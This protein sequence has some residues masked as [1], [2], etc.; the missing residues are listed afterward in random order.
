MR[1]FLL[2]PLFLF[3]SCQPKIDIQKENYIFNNNLQSYNESRDKLEEYYYRLKEYSEDK[4]SGLDFTTKISHLFLH[5]D[6]MRNDL[7][8]VVQE[9]EAL[10]MTILKQSGNVLTFP[11]LEFRDSLALHAYDFTN[12]RNKFSSGF[13]SFNKSNQFQKIKG[14]VFNFRKNLVQHAV[15]SSSTAEKKYSF[16]DPNLVDFKDIKAVAEML[17]KRLQT[18]APDDIEAV[19]QV[20][21]SISKENPFL[22]KAYEGFLEH[23]SVAE[24]INILTNIQNQIMRSSVDI[25]RLISSRFGG[26]EYRFNKIFSLVQGP[27]IVQKGD[28]IELKVCY[29]AYDSEDNPIVKIERA[30]S[31]QYLKEGI[32]YI[33]FKASDKDE[34]IKGKITILNKSGVPKTMNWEKKIKVLK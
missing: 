14:D 16:L 9:I 19:K 27:D 29:S 30:N 1:F 17:E 24:P 7:E 13:E 10:K 2:V 32:T 8:V 33:K 3:F 28:S 31:T 6:S 21:I 20:Y 26:E 25:C 23:K 18:A 4:S 11:K 12:Y 15:T 5:V 22:D 34:L